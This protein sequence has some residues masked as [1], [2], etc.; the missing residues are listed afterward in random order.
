MSPCA[1]P[2]DSR[3]KDR[4][5]S[6]AEFIERARRPLRERLARERPGYK[7]CTSIVDGGADRVEGSVQPYFFWA[8]NAAFSLSWRL[9]WSSAFKARKEGLVASRL[10]VAAL[11]GK[12]WSLSDQRKSV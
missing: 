1:H 7:D 5:F 10:G 3:I 2:G 11:A 8:A 4:V 6:K 9:V 12:A